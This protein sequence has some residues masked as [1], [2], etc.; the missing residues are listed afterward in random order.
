M[1][2]TRLSIKNVLRWLLVISVALIEWRATAT[3]YA[4]ALTRS[5]NVISFILNEDADNVKVLLNSGTTTNDMGGLVKGVHSFNLSGATNYQV[6]VSKNTPLG[7]TQ[8]SSDATVAVQFY[9]AKGEAVN[10]YPTNTALF[11][12][13]YVANSLAGTTTVTGSRPTTDGI[14]VLNPDQTD[15][16]GRGNTAATAGIAFDTTTTS[17]A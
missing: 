9:S 16:F 13:T 15:P 1:K 5:G 10:I 6:A 14:Y 17:Q 8:I 4:S 7:R 2:L 12:R 3:P 11:G